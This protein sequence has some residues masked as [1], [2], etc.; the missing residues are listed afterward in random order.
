MGVADDI[1]YR[2]WD[3]MIQQDSTTIGK[4]LGI[5][6]EL[7]RILGIRQLFHKLELNVLEN[8]IDK[9]PQ[10]VV[11]RHQFKQL[12]LRLVGF[13]DFEE[14]LLHRFNLT[15]QDLLDIDL[16]PKFKV[17]SYNT[18]DTKYS[19]DT[20]LKKLYDD[21]KSREAQLQEKNM[22]INDLKRQLEIA[23]NYSRQ[24]ESTIKQNAS[25]NDLLPTNS[26]E[27]LKKIRQ[28]NSIIELL[29]QQNNIYQQELQNFI[30]KDKQNE[31]KFTQ[32]ANEIEKSNKL[33]AG[34]Q[35]KLQL[36]DLQSS[37]HKLLTNLPFVKQ[38]YYYYHYKQQNK[39]WGIVVIN[40]FTLLFSLLFVLNFA[41][42]AWYLLMWLFTSKSLLEYT[43]DLYEQGWFEVPVWR[44]NWIEGWLWELEDWLGI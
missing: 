3:I 10:S 26:V 16:K 19:S 24:L 8:M 43:Y 29:E 13:H 18:Y 25:P 37:W 31:L 11:K 39:N 32:I 28:Q 40:I 17:E 20:E 34:L 12:I 1:V 42:L 21:I 22:E 5:I 35:N 30:E 38:Y 2:S 7:E 27:N 36:D 6:T 4:V 15:H 33:T 41:Q 9:T 44:N 14:F 23:N